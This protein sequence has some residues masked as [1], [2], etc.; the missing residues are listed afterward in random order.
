M[1]LIDLFKTDDIVQASTPFSEKWV[2]TAKLL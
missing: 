2:T 1:S